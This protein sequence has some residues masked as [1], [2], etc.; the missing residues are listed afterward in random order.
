VIGGDR[1]TARALLESDIMD[2]SLSPSFSSSLP[3][4]A[5]EPFRSV[6][7]E[8]EAPAA[9]RGMLPRERETELLEAYARDADPLALAELVRAHLPLVRSIVRRHRLSWLQDED[10]VAEGTLGLVEAARRFDPAFGARFATYAT[11]W[12][13]AKIQE[14]VF[15]FRR[16]VAPPDTRAGRR[17]LG[18]R[19]RAENELTQRLGR[20]PTAEELAGAVGVSP[21]EYREVRACFDTRDVPLACDGED[22]QTGV[23]DGDPSP[24]EVVA[25]REENDLRHAALARAIESLPARERMIVER[26]RLSV[27]PVPLHELARELLLSRERVRQLEVRGVSMIERALAA[28]EMG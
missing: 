8:A 24:E 4:E 20:V 25:T 17:I 19:T 18:R 6:A 2:T 28:P 10:L 27:D 26:R 1:W 21:Q 15:R 13:R 11:H 9:H 22:W 12:V 3:S 5:L 7:S 14:H 23:P 16:I